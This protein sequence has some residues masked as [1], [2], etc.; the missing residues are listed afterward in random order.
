MRSH[1]ASTPLPLML[2]CSTRKPTN[3]C[4]PLL[5]IIN[6]M[7]RA[8]ICIFIIYILVTSFTFYSVLFDIDG[9]QHVRKLFLWNQHDTELLYDAEP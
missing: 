8:I 5:K 1:K 2:F 6:D 4:R 7:L 3:F 9:L